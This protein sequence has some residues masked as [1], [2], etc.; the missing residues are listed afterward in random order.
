MR[1][2]EQI[3]KSS[4]H[5][6]HSHSQGG[7][8]TFRGPPNNFT[9]SIGGIN[10]QHPSHPLVS[11]SSAPSPGSHPFRGL[12]GG[13]V[14]QSIPAVI[15]SYKSNQNVQ[16]YKA[17]SLATSSGG[18]PSLPRDVPMPTAPITCGGAPT[19]PYLTSPSGQHSS[20]SKNSPGHGNDS[21]NINNS[22]CQSAPAKL[23]TLP[24][25]IPHQIVPLPSRPPPPL[26]IPEAPHS[27]LSSVNREVVSS[28]NSAIS[29]PSLIPYHKSV[30]VSSNSSNEPTGP[31]RRPPE[32]EKNSPKSENSDDSGCYQTDSSLEESERRSAKRMRSNEMGGRLGRPTVHNQSSDSGLSTSRQ[33]EDSSSGE[34]SPSFMDELDV[35]STE[36]NKSLVNVYLRR[37]SQPS[38]NKSIKANHITKI[39]KKSNRSA[40]GSRKVNK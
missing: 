4:P 33:S 32:S 26:V 25:L 22:I 3:S 27:S 35:K 31:L 30:S 29:I 16:L 37:V 7:D 39:E 15:K 8:T 34:D 24:S 18:R 20:N 12:N 38:L 14:V 9:F 23:E 21:N 36:H 11:L 6:S 5:L 19:T 2:L 1:H 28:N 17:T 10:T 13:P 40:H